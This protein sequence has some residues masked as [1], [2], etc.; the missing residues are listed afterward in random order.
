M[1]FPTILLPPLLLLTRDGRKFYSIRYYQWAVCMVTSVSRVCACFVSIPT[2]SCH[3]S[4]LT[5]GVITAV[6]HCRASVLLVVIIIP[7]SSIRIL[8]HNRLDK[9][10][11]SKA[12]LFCWAKDDK[13]RSLKG[14]SG[15][16]TPLQ[17]LNQENGRRG[18]TTYERLCSPQCQS[19][20]C[21]P[22]VAASSTR[23]SECQRGQTIRQREADS[24]NMSSGIT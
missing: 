6:R 18:S 2:R 1:R 5:L 15:S 20:Q 14:Q 16:P 3:N 8:A 9:Y 10:K 19:P 17:E 22:K 7:F 24:D 23:A 4:C 11:V 12:R 13:D 21:D